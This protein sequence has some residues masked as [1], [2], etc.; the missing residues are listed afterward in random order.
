MTKQVIIVRKDLKMNRGKEIAQASHASLAFM[1]HRILN[2]FDGRITFTPAIYEWFNKSFTKITLQVDSEEALLDVHKK[3]QEAGVES[4]LIK[5]DG[6]TYFDE[7]TY[8]CVGI[9]PDYSEKIDK[10]TKGLR[11]Y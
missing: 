11:L 8:T 2:T 9:G 4:Y 5:D 6:R 7:P 3:A 1:G 10:V